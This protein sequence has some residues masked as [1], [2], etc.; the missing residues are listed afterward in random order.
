MNQL[1]N[2]QL[3][4]HY[5]PYLNKFFPTFQLTPAIVE[6]CMYTKTKDLLWIIDHHPNFK[7]ILIL[8]GM[9]G[10]GFKAAPIIGKIASELIDSTYDN[11]YDLSIFQLSRL[12]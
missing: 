6:R 2:S 7:N 12:Y 4:S 1:S 11:R 10:H 5:Q 9:S 8:A 3:F